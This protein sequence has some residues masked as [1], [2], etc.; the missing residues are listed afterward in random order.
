[1]TS[2]TSWP[3]VFS[4]LP[5]DIL[6]TGCTVIAAVAIVI[7]IFD[8]IRP[9]AVMAHLDSSITHVASKFY[10]FENRLDATQFLS[11]K[12]SLRKSVKLQ[13]KALDLR[14]M[15][16]PTS[17]SPFKE[18]QLFFKGYTVAV[19]KCIYEAKELDAEIEVCNQYSVL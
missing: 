14:E 10:D 4:L 19:V 5:S 6:S 3:I 16:L 1:M 15:M 18:L 2:L 9:K 13:I 11:F 12:D 8:T 17:T 7:R